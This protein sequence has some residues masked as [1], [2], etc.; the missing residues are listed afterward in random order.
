[1]LGL[2]KPE[3]AINSQSSI[4]NIRCTKGEKGAHLAHR[5]IGST[6]VDRRV[7][8]EMI[9]FFRARFLIIIHGLKKMRSSNCIVQSSI[10]VSAE[11]IEIRAK[12]AGDY[13]LA[14]S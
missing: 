8:S 6:F 10:I 14:V 13:D 4:Y 1:M 3:I 12:R 7:K 2:E 9:L 5:E 11:R